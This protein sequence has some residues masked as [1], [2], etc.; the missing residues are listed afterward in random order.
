MRVPP[1]LGYYKTR[2]KQEIEEWQLEKKHPV[3][4]M[5]KL[6]WVRH[7]ARERR[8]LD[9]IERCKVK[10]PKEVEREESRLEMYTLM[11]RALEKKYDIR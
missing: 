7:R 8:Q 4:I 6:E 11:R 2:A 9:V 3:S 10:Y 5:V 1:T